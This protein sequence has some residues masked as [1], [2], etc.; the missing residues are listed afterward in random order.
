[1]VR[2]CKKLKEG[3]VVLSDANRHVS[4][5]FSIYYVKRDV[6]AAGGY[7]ASLLAT[8]IDDFLACFID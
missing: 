7:V 2:G 3:N 4:Y 6:V 8:L 1:L 5:V